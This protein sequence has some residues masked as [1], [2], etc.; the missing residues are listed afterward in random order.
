[1]QPVPLSEYLSTS[2][3]PDCDY[4][5]GV[6]LE[7]NL[8]ETSHS[9]AQTSLSAYIR[10]RTEGFWSGVELRVRVKPNRFR[11]PDITIIRGGKPSEPI[12]TTPPEVAVEFY[13]LK[14]LLPAYRTGST[15]AW[16]LEYRV[17]GWLIRRR[18]VPGFTP[19]MA[20]ARLE[21]VRFAKLQATW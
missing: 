17:F 10:Y 11:I 20:P 16:I 18:S 5:D 7:Q 14:V 1:M 19:T 2:Y 13:R 6:L 21:T 12:I 8:G 3:R 9:A 4:V 15:I